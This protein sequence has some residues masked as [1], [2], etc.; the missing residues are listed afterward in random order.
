MRRISGIL[1]NGQYLGI[2]RKVFE[3]SPRRVWHNYIVVANYVSYPKR[4]P[5]GSLSSDTEKDILNGV[6]ENEGN[7]SNT[8]SSARAGNKRDGN[9][10]RREGNKKESQ[11]TD[12][13]QPVDDSVEV[14]R[15]NLELNNEDPDTSS[16]SRKIGKSD[17]I[18]SPHPS[19]HG[20]RVLCTQ[21]VLDSEGDK[22]GDPPL[23]E[24]DKRAGPYW[25]L[26]W[27]AR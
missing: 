13:H 14:V 6:P 9:I 4:I 17:E 12:Y 24:G 15:D 5:N 22:I 27:T 20:D 8:R 23:S 7:K 16:E 18:A 21:L 25:M 3:A 10:A 1:Q 2:S 26:S 11:V 19:S